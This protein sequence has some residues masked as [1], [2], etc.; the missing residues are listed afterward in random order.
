MPDRS[1]PQQAALRLGCADFD[2]DLAF[3]TEQVGLRVALIFPADAPRVAEVVGHGLR[4]RLERDAV[5]T[6]AVLQLRAEAQVSHELVAP[7]GTRVHWLPAA[8]TWP[9]PVLRQSLVIQRA[10]ADGAAWEAGRAGLRYRDLLPDRQG[11]AFIASQIRV[12]DGGPVPDYVHF[13]ELGFQMIFCRRGWVRVVYEDQ[14][15]PFVMQPGDC[16]L[17][18]PT[19]RHRVLESS[20]GAEVIEICAPA[21]HLTR[22]D[23]DLHLPTDALKPERLFGGQRFVR[24]IAAH[25]TWAPGRDLGFEASDTGIAEATSGLAS[26]QVLRPNS[27]TSDW[28]R[29]T[30]ELCF[31]FVLD[32]E[33][34]LELADASHRLQPDDCVALPSGLAYRLGARDASLRLLSVSLPATVRTG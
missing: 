2:A 26:V 22:A 23:P 21:E 7:N 13:H 15:D 4:L 1:T 11:G 17:Q 28:Q 34:D 10:A 8:E 14:G 9:Q 5:N 16:V 20:A 6:P 29:H 30:H 27:S 33:L 19:I 18:P 25:A 32:G 24:H 31:Y 12:L 3:F